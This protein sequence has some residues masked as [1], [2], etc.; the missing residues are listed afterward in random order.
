[1]MCLEENKMRKSRKREL[2]A[3]G[4]PILVG[5][6]FQRRCGIGVI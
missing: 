3:Q 6:R 4:R 1:M 5:T 2:E